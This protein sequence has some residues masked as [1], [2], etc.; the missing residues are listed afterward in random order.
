MI[1]V[2][3]L[4]VN[5]LRCGVMV[6]RLAPLVP[7]K[8]IVSYLNSHRQS[9]DKIATRNVALFLQVF[10]KLNEPYAILTDSEEINNDFMVGEF[11]SDPDKLYLSIDQL[12]NVKRLWSVTEQRDLPLS[13]FD[14]DPR[15][16]LKEKVIFSNAEVRLYE[17][18]P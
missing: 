16:V 11:I 7:L 10:N 17:I 6:G 3:L 18:N 14:H 9:Q 13:W 2:S 15:I 12:K 4:I 1:D 5:G 8:S